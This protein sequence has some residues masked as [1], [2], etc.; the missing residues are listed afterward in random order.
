MVEPVNRIA[1]LRP[2]VRAPAPQ[3]IKKIVEEVFFQNICYKRGAGS[4]K[5]E[6]GKSGL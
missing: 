5:A 1:W 2:W 6:I 4:D 3:K